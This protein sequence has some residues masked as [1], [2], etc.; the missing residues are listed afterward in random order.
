M[1]GKQ[2]KTSNERID[3]RRSEMALE[4]HYKPIGLRAVLAAHRYTA[5]ATK[6]PEAGGKPA[7]P[8]SPRISKE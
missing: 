8:V 3:D 4:R 6:L 1:T 5:R 7:H 2:A